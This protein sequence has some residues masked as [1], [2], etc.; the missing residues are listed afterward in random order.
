MTKP[1]TEE[2][3][4]TFDVLSAPPTKNEFTKHRQ[5]NDK[6]WLTR[7]RDEVYIYTMSKVHL[8]NSMKMMEA[9]KQEYTRAYRGMAA[10]LKLREDARKG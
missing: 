10:E 5:L 6:I 3:Q 9:L 2:E 8:I 4:Y 7:E 1:L